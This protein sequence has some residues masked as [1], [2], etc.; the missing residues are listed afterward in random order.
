MNETVEQLQIFL[1]RYMEID[2]RLASLLVETAMVRRY[3]KDEF[4]LRQ[5]DLSEETFFILKGCVRSFSLVS[6]EDKTLDFYCEEEPIMPL[7]L[8]EKRPASHSLIA[9][10]ELILIASTPSMEEEAFKRHPEIKNVCLAMAETM[11]HSLQKKFT[12][13]RTSSAEDR[14][15]ALREQRPDLLQRVPQYHIAS[16]LGIKP[17]S[18]SRIRRRLQSQNR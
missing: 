9:M 2:E 17:E 3:G 6:G 11:S 4:L 14:Y 13:Y 15:I 18:L 8:G 5:G 1:S 12:F 16:Y 10:E 7:E